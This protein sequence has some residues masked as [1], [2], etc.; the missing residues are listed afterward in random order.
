[1]MCALSTFEPGE[2]DVSVVVAGSVDE[3]H[4]KLGAQAIAESGQNYEAAVVGEPTELE[5]V[6]A[7]KGSV[8]WEIS[9]RGKSAHTSKPHLGVNAITMMAHVIIEL[10]GLNERLKERGDQ[11]V[12]AP[13]LTVTLIEGGLE[14]TTVPPLCRITVDRRLVPGEEPEAAI[15][16]VRK[17]IEELQVRLPQLRFEISAPFFVDHAPRSSAGSRIASI[18]EEA[19]RRVTNKSGFKGVPYGTDAS[20]LSRAGIP[21]VILGP[22][23]IDQAHTPN[24]YVETAQ[25][26]KAIEMYRDIM[27]NY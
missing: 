15:A 13:T 11:L 27:K 7:H 22:G 14:A 25:L 2:L 23:S 20:K 5:L 1:M 10:H 17:A 6:V 18:A 3:E 12:G 4:R 16:E 19:C 24:E 9:V 21:C 8:R 26:S